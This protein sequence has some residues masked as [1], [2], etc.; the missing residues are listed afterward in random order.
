[1]YDQILVDQTEN[2]PAQADEGVPFSGGDVR[3]QCRG[4]FCHQDGFGLAVVEKD[5]PFA[6]ADHHPFGKLGHEG[7]Q[8]ILFLFGFCFCPVNAGVDIDPQ[9]VVSVRQ[10]VDFLCEIDQVRTALLLQ[11]MRRIG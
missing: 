5:L 4:V 8:D 1:M 9:S 3:L 10:F 2:G 6:V 11:A 7:G